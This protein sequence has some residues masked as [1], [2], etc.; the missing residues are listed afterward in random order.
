RDDPLRGRQCQ[1]HHAGN[2]RLAAGELRD[3]LDLRRPDDHAVDG[4]PLDLGLLEGLDLLGDLLGQL[5]H[6]VPPPARY[7]PPRHVPP[8][9]LP[10]PT[11]R[12]VTATIPPPPSGKSP[13]GPAYSS[14]SGS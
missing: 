5:G 14:G 9:T 13:A 7:P 10:L 4:P 8:P 1:A 12:Q 3:V 6:P 11:A 2:Q